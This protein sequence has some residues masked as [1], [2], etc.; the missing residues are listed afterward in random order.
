MMHRLLTRL[1]Q[2]Q[3]GTA[4]TEFTMCLPIWIV[5]MVGIANLQTLGVQTTRVQV[6]AQ[7]NLWVNAIDLT[8]NDKYENLTR[9]G[10][11]EYAAMD[12][13]SAP[14][15]D[16]GALDTV[17]TAHGG[18]MAL[19]HWVESGTMVTATKPLHKNSMDVAIM[20]G[21]SSIGIDHSTHLNERELPKGLLDDLNTDALGGLGDGGTSGIIASIAKLALDASGA[22]IPL[23]TAV[24]YGS[25]SG[26]KFGQQV[27]IAGTSFNVGA[28]YDVLVAPKPF[29]GEHEIGG[30]RGIPTMNLRQSGIQPLLIARLIAES[31]P[32]YEVH[33]RWGKSEWE[34][35]SGSYEG[36]GDFDPDKAA[37][38][39]KEQGK[40]CKED[41]DHNNQVQSCRSGCSSQPPEDQADCRDGCGDMRSID[42]ACNG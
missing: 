7:R 38:D 18:A 6:T 14:Y 1:H 23:A 11:G 29:D 30:E 42:P 13:S 4:L 33:Q 41:M 37:E 20:M 8:I 36:L 16:A 40:K 9:L 19:G 26:N 28:Q 25:V 22:T 27:N 15:S 12:K 2:E 31:V 35:D 21:T 3:E 17:A 10:G 34:G 32:N 39:G 24:R 5:I